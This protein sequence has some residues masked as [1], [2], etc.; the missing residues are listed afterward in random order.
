VFNQ[1]GSGLRADDVANFSAEGVLGST[2]T[3]EKKAWTVGH[4][5]VIHG[6]LSV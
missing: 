1:T 5:M 2:T 4:K 3:D 6:S